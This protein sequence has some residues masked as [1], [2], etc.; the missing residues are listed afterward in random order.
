MRAHS[1]KAPAWLSGLGEKS[2]ASVTL[3]CLGAAGSGGSQFLAWNRQLPPWLRV[4]A[5]QLPG[6]ESRYREPPLTDLAALSDALAAA[7][8]AA[9][10]ERFAFFGHSF[11]ALLAYE[12]TRALR[13]N[14]AAQPCHLCVAGRDAPHLPLGYV[15]TYHL[16]EA[17]F[18]EVLHRHGAFDERILASMDLLRFFLP[19]IRADLEM[20]TEYV[21]RFEPPLHLP[22]T[23]LRGI[24]DRV[25]VIE[26][27]RRWSELT[28]C[29]VDTHECE[30]DH[31]FFRARPAQLFT[32]LTTA[33]APYSDW[34]ISRS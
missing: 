24:D 29:R 1:N 8:A 34:T 30:G 18:I 11:G 20:N 6:R 26:R 17:E 21:H 23:A 12:T 28:L 7:I 15:K 13:R 9:R 25:C 4:V 5:V 19:V 22:I 16:P 32:I 3:L 14:G 31:F 10:L 33:L 2:A 27:L